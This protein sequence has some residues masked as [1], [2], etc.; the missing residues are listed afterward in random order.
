V[1]KK[2]SPAVAGKAELGILLSKSG[3]IFI[4][5][6]KEGVEGGTAL[7]VSIRPWSPVHLSIQGES[8]I[9]GA[10]LNEQLEFSVVPSPSRMIAGT[11]AA[12]QAEAARGVPAIPVLRIEKPALVVVVDTEEE[13]DWSKA[14][15]RSAISVD[16]IKHLDRTQ[17]IFERY[18]IKPTYVVDFAVASQ[19]QA[20]R[21]IREW[22]ADGQ[23]TLGAHLHPWVNPPYEEEL[24]VRNSFPGNLPAALERAKLARLTDTIIGNFGHRPTVYRAGRYGIGGA[25]GGILEELDYEV[26]TSVVPATDFSEGGGP[27]FTNA[28]PDPFWFGPTGRV[29][30][31]PLTVGWCGSLRGR[32]GAL[33]PALMSRLAMQCHLPGV[34]ARLGL[35]ERIRLTPEGMSLADLKRVTDTLLSAGRRLFVLSYHSPSVVPGN[36]P[37]VRDEAELQRFLGVIE[38]YCEYFLGTCAG[39]GMTFDNVRSVYLKA[40]PAGAAER[41]LDT[42]ELNLPMIGTQSFR[43]MHGDMNPGLRVIEAG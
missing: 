42:P 13:F 43:S 10:Q 26:D 25:T 18:G 5:R 24:S 41:H 2:G 28:S 40:I 34:F 21:P 27:D 32:A 20:F 23:C 19:E 35:L 17:R 1:S 31:V 14:F 4:G 39:A 12:H 6:V 7:L 30:E 36:T 9:D 22:L 33:A 37:Y 16:H 38:Q 15:S 11:A 8:C 3:A 29:L